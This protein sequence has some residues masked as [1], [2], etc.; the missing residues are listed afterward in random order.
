MIF[1][2]AQAHV[3][4]LK[5]GEGCYTVATL[6]AEEALRQ[7]INSHQRGGRERGDKLLQ[8]S[9]CALRPLVDDLANDIM[10]LH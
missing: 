1:K 4:I 9:M 10:S 8:M 7:E 5:T 6:Q 3:F 2:N